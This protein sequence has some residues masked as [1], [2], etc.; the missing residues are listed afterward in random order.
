[1]KSDKSDFCRETEM[2]PIIDDSGNTEYLCLFVVSSYILDSIV[3]TERQ[4]LYLDLLEQDI[5]VELVSSL[6]D[7]IQTGDMIFLSGNEDLNG[8][9]FRCTY[10]ILDFC[11]RWK[12]QNAEI[13][14]DE[15][16]YYKSEMPLN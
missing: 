14:W 13:T 5:E 6:D 9:S 2:V 11:E 3:V 15:E 1:M 12:K 8:I 4:L 7:D 10:K 16:F